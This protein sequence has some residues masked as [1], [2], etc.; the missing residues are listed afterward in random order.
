ML[1]NKIKW[2]HKIILPDGTITP[3]IWT[4]PFDK[5]GL[6]DINFKNKRVLDIGCLDGGYSFYAEQQGAKEV[7]S[8]DIIETKRNPNAYPQGQCTNEAYIYAHKAFNSKAKYI[9]PYSLYDVTPE[10]FGSFDIVFF[11]GVIY[12]IAHPLL[13]LERINKVLNKNGVLALESEVSRSFTEFYHKNRLTQK[14]VLPACPTKLKTIIKQKVYQVVRSLFEDQ[15]EVFANKDTSVFWVPTPKILERFIDFAGF[16][17]EK[18][19][20]SGET[21]IGIYNR[22]V[23]ICKKLEAP[24]PIYAV[25]SLY[26][27]YKN[28]FTNFPFK[29]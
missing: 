4:L 25:D 12:H 22:A 29:K 7:V 20:D 26:T 23:Y 8:I 18:K 9:F 14:P 5:W 27:H 24:N 17:I 13:A 15:S 1:D 19:I 6:S 11:L 10:I 2:I 3:G 28:R 21:N 16:S